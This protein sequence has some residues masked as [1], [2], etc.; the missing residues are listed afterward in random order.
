MSG[1]VEGGNKVVVGGGRYG[2]G[3]PFLA[4]PIVRM[5][6]VTK[7]TE[8]IIVSKFMVGFL[9]LMIESLNN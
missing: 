4:D 1:V 8:R 6:S 5:D 7:I 9:P 2:M 3:V